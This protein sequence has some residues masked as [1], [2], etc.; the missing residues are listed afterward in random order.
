MRMP[1]ARSIIDVINVS[2]VKPLYTCL[3]KDLIWQRREPPRFYEYVVKKQ[4]LCI[5]NSSFIRCYV[6][7]ITIL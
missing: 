7:L 2:Y 5:T 3:S 4:K 1:G 6:L